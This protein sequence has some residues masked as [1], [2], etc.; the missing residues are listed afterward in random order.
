VRERKLDF[1]GGVTVGFPSATGVSKKDAWREMSVLFT[2]KVPVERRNGVTFDGVTFS[3]SNSIIL[4]LPRAL[5]DD[6]GTASMIPPTLIS[7]ELRG[8]LLTIV[9][10]GTGSGTMIHISEIL[11]G[12][13]SILQ[14][15]VCYM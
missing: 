7:T 9:L 10:S 12:Y 13:E 8:F 4:L 11:D 2:V 15:R 14:T 1:V 3:F 5:A 6:L